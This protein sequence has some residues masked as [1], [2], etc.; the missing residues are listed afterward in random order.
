VLAAAAVYLWT[1]NNHITTAGRVGI[2]VFVAVGWTI[3]LCLHEFD[4]AAVAWWAGDRSVEGRGYLTLDPRRYMHGQL[5]IVLPIIIVLM[6]GIGLPG[7]AVMIDRRF[8]PSKTSRSLVSAAGPLTNAVVAVACGLPLRMHWIGPNHQMFA[9][10]LAF[11][12]LLE[13]AVTVLN[14]LPIPG[15]DGFGVI[16]PFLRDETVR[17]A[18]PIANYVFLGLFV[19]LLSSSQAGSAFYNFCFRE[20]GH[21]GVQR[22]LAETGQLLFTFWRRVQ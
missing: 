4:H 12:A 2:F 13:V 5:S 11:L 14:S 7:G 19:L 17:A 20:L 8:I 22:G 21:L 3:S 9:S 18:M 16:A 15:L 10:A 1:R 6:G